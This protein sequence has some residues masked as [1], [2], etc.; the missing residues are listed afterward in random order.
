MLGRTVACWAADAWSWLRFDNTCG[1]PIGPRTTRR[2][3]VGCTVLV[4]VLSATQ[5]SARANPP[6]AAAAAAASAA[7]APS[8][9]EMRRA[10][11][12]ELSADRHFSASRIDATAENGIVVLTGNVPLSAWKER[13]AR[14]AAVVHGVRAVVNRVQVVPV[15]RPDRRVA[16]DVRKALRGTNG[17]AKTPITV[18][19]QDGVVELTGAISSWEQQQLAERV[20]RHVPGVRF[21]LNQLTSRRSIRRTSA[22]VAGEVQ[23][24]LDWDPLVQHDPIRV[25]VQSSRVLLAGTTGSWAERR[26]AITLAWVKGV[27]AVDAEALVV[28]TTKRP[29]PNVRLRFPTDS[30]IF[31]T[32]H[33]LGRHWPSVPISALRLAVAGGVVTV[34]GNVATLAETRTVETMVRS[35]VGVV[36]VRSELRGPWWRPPPSPP[37]PPKPNRPKRV[38]RRR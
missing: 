12:L 15:S 36:E 10:V 32:I 28:D 23:S 8:D 3:A 7:V 27:T 6:P 5:A 20:A 24:R 37:P 11:L 18:R 25:S 4:I 2:G 33:E 9:L 21:C 19:V 13:A 34:R 22:V 31:A 26:R 30:E 17:L 35:A 29:W 38:R 14:V 1:A 16:E